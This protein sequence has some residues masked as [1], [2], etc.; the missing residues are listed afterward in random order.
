MCGEMTRL[1]IWESW[2]MIWDDPK[3]RKKRNG[4]PD[5]ENY[6]YRLIFH[7]GAEVT[8]LL[9]RLTH[10]FNSNLLCCDNFLHSCTSF[11]A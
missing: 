6:D 3:Q 9:I 1:D 10:S 2:L 7:G 4:K 5:R 8:A 11:S